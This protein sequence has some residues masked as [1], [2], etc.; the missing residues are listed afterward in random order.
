MSK[1][2]ILNYELSYREHVELTVFL[3]VQHPLIK[4]DVVVKG[5]DGDGVTASGEGCLSL[6]ECLTSQNVLLPAL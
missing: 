4:D 3:V 6:A 2:L 1:S 5:R